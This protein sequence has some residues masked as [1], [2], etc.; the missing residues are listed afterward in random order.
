MASRGRATPPELLDPPA[1]PPDCL[2]QFFVVTLL[3]QVGEN[4]E[5]TPCA[6]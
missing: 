3:D 5:H 2:V 6:T 4:L 1:M